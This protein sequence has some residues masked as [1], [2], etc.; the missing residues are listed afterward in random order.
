[1]TMGS[2]IEF[3]S[4]RVERFRGRMR[5]RQGCGSWGRQPF[6]DVLGSEMPP[7]PLRSSRG[8]HRDD[9]RPEGLWLCSVDET[10]WMS[11]PCREVHRW[12]PI[13]V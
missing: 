6:G 9:A 13:F 1:M 7:L 10:A 5:R 8:V 4:L 2:T 12:D 3:S 11:S